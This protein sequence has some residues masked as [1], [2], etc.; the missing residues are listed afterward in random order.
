MLWMLW[1]LQGFFLMLCFEKNKKAKKMYELQI[2]LYL[3][4]MNKK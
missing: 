1:N 2:K 3:N 4:I